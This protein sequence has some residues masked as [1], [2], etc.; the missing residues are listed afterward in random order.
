MGRTVGEVEELTREII[1]I[2]Q[3]RIRSE[4]A[5]AASVAEAQE[6]LHLLADDR[7]ALEES[8]KRLQEGTVSDL[9]RSSSKSKVMIEQ[10]RAVQR[11]RDFF[12]GLQGAYSDIE[13]AEDPNDVA[14]VKGRIAFALAGINESGETFPYVKKS[15]S[16]VEQQVFASKGLLVLKLALLS[17]PGN[18][19]AK[20]AFRDSWKSCGFGLDQL[21]QKINENAE[22]ATAAFYAENGQLVE[23]LTRSDAVGKVMLLSTEMAT[24][25]DA[26]QYWVQNLFV[27]RSGRRIE[28][29]KETIARLFATSRTVKTLM[30]EALTAVGEASERKLMKDVTAGLDRVQELVMKPGGMIETLAA[31]AAARERSQELGGKLDAMIR[32]EKEAGDKGV[33]EAQ[34]QQQR[35]ASFVDFVVRSVTILLAAAIATVLLVTIWLGWVIARSIITL[36][37]DLQAAKEEAESASRAKSQFLANISHEIRTPMNGVLGLLELLKASSLPAKQRNYVN[38][39]LSSGITLLGVINDVLDFSKIEAGQME[40]SVE[41]FDLHLSVEET[42]GFLA[43]QT[44]AKG[45]ELL[46]H[47]TPDVPRTARGDVMRLRQIL[48]NLLGNA[49]KFTT[50]GEIVVRVSLLSGQEGSLCRF[51]V[52]DTG[53]GIPVHA[54]EKIFDSFSQADASTTRKFGGT[55]LGL[56]IARQLVRMMGG[57]IGVDSEVGVGST[58]WFTVPFEESTPSGELGKTGAAHVS[59]EALKGLKAL[60]VDRQL[61]EQTNTGRHA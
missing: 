10:F 49:V 39:A 36:V 4:N 45:I 5:A 3:E 13:R 24:V 57:E 56:S 37:K 27:E 7:S 2:T 46:C 16:T 59:Y 43:E 60:V 22:D 52:S 1:R 21:A 20:E 38:T 9:A 55:G 19:A 58:F 41:D 50:D 32:L 15:A 31:A 18:A 34:G 48:I 8:L 14:I 17:D 47:I 51:E 30:D 54:R 40:L 61:H 33:L 42:V 29:T 11:V 6:R 35:S 25:T 12:Q 28:R 26:I 23:K 44:Q 53:I